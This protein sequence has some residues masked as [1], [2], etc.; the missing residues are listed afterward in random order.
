MTTKVLKPAA[1]LDRDGVLVADTGYVHRIDEMQ[2]LP[3][4][5]ATLKELQDRGHLL[6]VVTNQAGVARG[7]YGEAD[8]VA[9]HEE[10][11]RRIQAESGAVIDAFYYCPHHP[12]GEAFQYA[13]KCLC[14]KPGTAM[15]EQA[16]QEFPID[17]EL[18]FMVGDRKSDVECAL[19]AHIRGF[20]IASG[21]YDL[22]PEPYANISSLA[23][24][25]NHA[26]FRQ[27]GR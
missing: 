4:V 5:A 12:D 26:D 18:S 20:Q 27:G 17:W 25:L 6:I 7:Y 23:D 22:H 8:V 9:F 10:L 15:L 16:G 1:F 2:I 11:A 14:R 3:G 13:V 19:N 24:L 21:Q